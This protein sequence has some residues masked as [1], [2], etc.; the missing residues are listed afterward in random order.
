MAEND[1]NQELNMNTNWKKVLDLIKENKFYE[2]YKN[3]TLYKKEG[4]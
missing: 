3:Y 4:G 1:E 2:I